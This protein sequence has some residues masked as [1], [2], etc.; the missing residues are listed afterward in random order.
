MQ[1]A[2]Q[3]QMPDLRPLWKQR[4]TPRLWLSWVSLWSEFP[5]TRLEADPNCPKTNWWLFRDTKF[6]PCQLQEVRVAAHN[7]L[8]SS[9][10]FNLKYR[11]V[12]GLALRSSL[13]LFGKPLLYHQTS[14]CSDP[15]NLRRSQQVSCKSLV[16]A[17]FKV[18]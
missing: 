4:P 1:C 11:P 6:H 12:N 13:F 17:V 9:R 10:C 14:V 2:S 16:G 7:K 15:L 5:A 3:N 8:Q 18:W